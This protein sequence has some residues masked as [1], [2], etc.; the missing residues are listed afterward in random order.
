MPLLSHPLKSVSW[1]SGQNFC[2]S[3]WAHCPLTEYQRKEFSLSSLQCPFSYLCTLI[4][5]PLDLLFSR[6]SS[7]SSLHHQ[8]M[9]TGN[10]VRPC[11]CPPL[12]YELLSSSLWALPP[13][14]MIDQRLL[15]M[16]WQWSVSF[17]S[18]HGS[19]PWRAHE[20]PRQ[21]AT[22]QGNTVLSCARSS[23]G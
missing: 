7:P 4:K 12:K 13:V 22:R 6:Q 3:V 21:P 17:F 16:A 15:K 19:I 10:S 11:S 18:I 20:L 8:V 1:C 23:L 5:S 9:V 14:A 2:V